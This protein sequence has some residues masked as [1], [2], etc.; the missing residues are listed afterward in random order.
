MKKIILAF[1][2]LAASFVAGAQKTTPA[3]TGVHFGGGVRV[4]LPV[5]TFG[6]YNTFALGAELQGEYMFTPKVSA[7]VTT[8]YTNFFGKDLGGGFKT[9]SSGIIPL[10]GG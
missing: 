7:T 5:G 8:G 2:V 9:P 6:D 4:G 1:T 10:L 3:S